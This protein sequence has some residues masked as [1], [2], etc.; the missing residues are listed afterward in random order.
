MNIVKRLEIYNIKDKGL[1]II[2]Y[3]TFNKR[4]NYILLEKIKLKLIG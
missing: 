4:Y 3:L 2:K 1:D